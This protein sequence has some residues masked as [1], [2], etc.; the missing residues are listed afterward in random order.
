MTVCPISLEI[1]NESM[2]GKRIK[3]VS[4]LIN[5]HFV[6]SRIR[7]YK[8]EDEVELVNSNTELHLKDRILLIA[9]SADIKAISAFFGRE[10]HTGWEDA[11]KNLMVCRIRITKPELQGKT[12]AQLN[13]RKNLAVNIT[14]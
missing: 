4:P 13:V 5:R 1:T 14:I 9:S 8:S 2:E 6:I 12:L 11:G 3:D 7:H 10:I